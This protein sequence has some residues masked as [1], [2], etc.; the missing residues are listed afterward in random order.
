MANIPAV[1]L[2]REFDAVQL[3][4]TPVTQADTP[5]SQLVIGQKGLGGSIQVSGTF[6]GMTIALHGSNDGTNFYVLKDL[7]GSDISFTAAGLK[8]FTSACAYLKPVISGGAAASV[9]I[10]AILR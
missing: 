8:D 3:Q 4:W 1:R 7:Q 6:G 2:D 9:T 10:T 5:L